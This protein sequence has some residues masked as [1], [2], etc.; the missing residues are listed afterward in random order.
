[1]N[2][3][4]KKKLFF[5]FGLYIIEGVIAF[6]IL[7]SIPVDPKNTSYMGYSAPRFMVLL[8]ILTGILFFT[9]MIIF[10]LKKS[11]TISNI[12]RALQ[13]DN[14]SIYF[15]EFIGL[16]CTLFLLLTFSYRFINSESLSIYYIRLLPLFLWGNLICIQGLFILPSVLFDCDLWKGIKLFSAKIRNI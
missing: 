11:K 10:E 2:L 8:I 3:I 9:A 1:M 5:L 6:L 15:L 13:E 12:I 14:R 16:I 4:Q 7:S